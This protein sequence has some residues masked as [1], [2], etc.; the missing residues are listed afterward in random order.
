M[1]AVL[2]SYKKRWTSSALRR[3]DSTARRARWRDIAGELTA[4]EVAPLKMVT[5]ALV[6][7]G[8]GI[9]EAMNGVG[10]TRS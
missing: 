3:W 9:K 1:L 2:Q 7:F 10:T 6:Y 5:A 4:G 8:T